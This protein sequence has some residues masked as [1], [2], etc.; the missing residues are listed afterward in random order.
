M[1]GDKELSQQETLQEISDEWKHRNDETSSK[2]G[3]KRS[4]AKSTAKETDT[5]SEAKEATDKA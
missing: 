2:S 3:R 5:K 1:T 4:S